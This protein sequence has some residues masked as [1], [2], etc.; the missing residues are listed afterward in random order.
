MVSPTRYINNKY[1]KY[2]TFHLPDQRKRNGT[3]L[4]LYINQLKRAKLAGNYND[5]LTLDLQQS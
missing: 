4:I 3:P 2:L 5:K 1:L